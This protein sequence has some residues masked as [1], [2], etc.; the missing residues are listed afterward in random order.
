MISKVNNKAEYSRVKELRE[1]FESDGQRN[2][3]YCYKYNLIFCG[4][5]GNEK[6][7]YDTDQ[8]LRDFMKT[9][10]NVEPDIADYMMFA[11]VHRIGTS[12]PRNIIAKFVQMSDLDN[13]LNSGK[14]LKKYKSTKVLDNGRTI[15]YQTY[16]VQEHLPPELV[17][18]KNE[19]WPV[20]KQAGGYGHRRQFRVIGSNIYLFING[21]KYIPRE[22]EVT[23]QGLTPRKRNVHTRFTSPSPQ[24]T[25]TP[26]PPESSHVNSSTSSNEI[27][28][29]TQESPNL[30]SQA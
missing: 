28:M 29:E 7:K 25:S 15:T 13:V 5:A 8:V 4:I 17:E 6:S 3:A 2:R 20:Y 22:N 26:I 9:K 24:L 19:L 16:K 10:L 21:Q 11:D 30:L 12:Q 1:D 18:R 14:N 23:E 27:I